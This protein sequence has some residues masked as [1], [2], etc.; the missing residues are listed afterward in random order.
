MIQFTEGQKEALREKAGREPW[1]LEE[2]KKRTEILLNR[3]VLIPAKGIGN[4]GMYYFCRTCSV[5]LTFSYDKPYTHIC[6]VCGREYGGEPY[7]SS[8]WGKVN[9]T[10]SQGARDFGKWYFL[11]GDL[12]LAGKAAQIIEGYGKVYPGYEVHGDIP[13]NGPG[14]ANAQTLDEA[15]FLTDLAYAYDFVKDTMTDQGKRLAEEGLFRPGLAF[16]LDHR[17]RQIHNHE[18]IVNSA[19]GVLGILLGEQEAVDKALYEP[20]GLLYQ[21]EHGMGKDHLWFEGT[22]GYHYYA[23]ENFL[24]YEKFAVHT[25]YSL[26]THPNYQKMFEVVLDFVQAD[27]E[28]PKFNDI[29]VGH[30]GLSSKYLYEFVYP[31]MPTKKM[32][33]VMGLIYENQER[34]NEEAFFYGSDSVEM[35]PVKQ[36]TY[37][38][39]EGVGYTVF[40]GKDRRYLSVKHGRFGG[41]H[42][43]YDQMGISYHSHGAD[44]VPDLGTT[45]YGA[46]LHYAYYKNTGTHNTVCIGEANQP[47]AQGKTLRYE[48]EGDMVRLEVKADW[49]E[50]CEMPDSFTIVQWDEEAYRNVSMVRKIAWTDDYWIDVFIVRGAAGRTIDYTMHITGDRVT[51]GEDRDNNDTWLSSGKPMKYIRLTGREASY[52]TVHHTYRIWSEQDVNLDIY[53]CYDGGVLYYGKGPANPSTRDMEYEIWRKTGDWAV[54]CQVLQSHAPGDET[55]RIRSVGFCADSA[56]IKVTVATKAAVREVVFDLEER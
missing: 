36:E 52:G 14:K 41:E 10:N 15:V 47:P 49:R 24:E 17:H 19:I 37:H 45:G 33:Q 20:Y 51:G 6:P 53:S 31:R 13:Y 34:R 25:P 3:D 2:L 30:K 4:W 48:T 21:L 46:E 28:F 27:G 1:I 23:L 50:P 35:L 11:T 44:V 16:L 8:W 22:L 32:K 39:E 9:K 56:E 55:D 18:V 40:R 43:H 38:P 12:E 42:D 5:P 54:F 26:I 29:Y 7:D